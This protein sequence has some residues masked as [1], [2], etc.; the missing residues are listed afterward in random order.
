MSDDEE[1][2]YNT[3]R[4]IKTGR[5]VKLLYT[6]SKVHVHI[7]DETNIMLTTMPGLRPPHS[8]GKR[9]HP[10]IHRPHPTKAGSCQSLLRPPHIL[11]L[12]YKHSLFR[13]APRLGT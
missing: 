1:G 12:Q 8:P 4:H 13:S 10:R 9:Q 7:R 2:D 11:P 5:G 3:I 6:K